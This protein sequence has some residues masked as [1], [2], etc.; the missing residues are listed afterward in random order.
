MAKASNTSLNAKATCV[1]QKRGAGVEYHMLNTKQGMIA[2]AHEHTCDASCAKHASRISQELTENRRPKL[3][4]VEAAMNTMKA[5]ENDARKL[6]ERATGDGTQAPLIQLRD[7]TN[8][9]PHEDPR[10]TKTTKILQDTESC[11]L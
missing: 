1:V 9:R 4:R 10:Q 8:R 3:R 6:S 7:N 2:A 11:D 5:F